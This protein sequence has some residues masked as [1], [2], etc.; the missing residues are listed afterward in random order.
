MKRVATK[1]L[2]LM[3]CYGLI[4][5]LSMPLVHAA[6][7]GPPAGWA[8]VLGPLLGLRYLGS[9]QGASLYAWASA[10]TCP[11]IAMPFFKTGIIGVVALLLGGCLWI[12]SGAVI[13]GMG[14]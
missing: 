7:Q 2:V 13:Y 11:L 12:F 4:S 8:E 10:V 14:V 9:E 5:F 1:S 3:V 6:Y